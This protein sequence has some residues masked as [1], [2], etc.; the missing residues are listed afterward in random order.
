MYVSVVRV[1]IY[2]SFNFRERG[3]RHNSVSSRTYSTCE[4]IENNYSKREH[5]GRNPAGRLAATCLPAK[6][7]YLSLLMYFEPIQ[8]IQ[9]IQSYHSLVADVHMYLVTTFDNKVDRRQGRLEVPPI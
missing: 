2:A 4:Q 8:P 5:W 1:I 9:L 3:Q 6:I 7:P